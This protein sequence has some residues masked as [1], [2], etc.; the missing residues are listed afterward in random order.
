MNLKKVLMGGAAT[1]I[2]LGASA[3]SVLAA[4]NGAQV[5][6]F[7]NEPFVWDETH[8]LGTQ[9]PGAAEKFGEDVA[10]HYEAMNAETVRVKVNGDV[11]WTLTQH[12]TATITALDDEALLYEGPFQVEEIA[13]DNGGDAGCLANDGH[14]WLGN[15]SALWSNLDFAQYNWKI[16]GNSV[17][18]FNITIKGAGNYCY[19]GIHEDGAY[20][21]GCN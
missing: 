8:E 11:E 12:G 10:V 9:F 3:V 5:Y 4:G 20:G 2:M 16:T 15:C 13:R 7:A 21:P 18:T 17:D 19:G 14:A 6:R 1:A